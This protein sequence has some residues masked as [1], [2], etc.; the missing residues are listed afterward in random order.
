M[1]TIRH[2]ALP[3]AFFLLASL[4]GL[5]VT[6]A[7]LSVTVQENATQ[8]FT[9]STPS[10]WT[11]SCGTISSTGLY[12]APLYPSSTCKVTATP[13]NGT[14]AAS[15]SINVVS[16]VTMTPVAATTPQGQTQQFTASTSVTWSAKCGTITASGLYT[17]SGTVGSY[18][19]IQGTAI[20]NPKYMV[21]GYDKIAAPVASTFSISPL[22]VTISEGGTQQFTVGSGATFSASCGSISAAGVFTAPLFPTSCT[23][24][25][26]A[27]DGSGQTASTNATVTSPIAISPASATTPLGQTQQF[28]ANMSVAW[29]ASCGTINAA[30]LFTAS[31][32]Q[33]SACTVTATGTGGTAYTASAIETVGAPTALTISPL[34]PSLLE[35]ATQQFTS[36][37]NATWIASCGTIGTTTGTYTAPLAAGTCTITANATDGSGHTASTIA[38]VT[39]PLVITPSTAATPQGSTQQFTANMQSNWTSSCGS[40]NAAGLFTAA[41]AQGSVCTIS[42]TAATAPAYTSSAADTVGAAAPLTISPLNQSLLENATQQFTSSKAATWTSSCGTIGSTT[43]A[44]TAPLAPGIC[45]ITAAATDG[46]GNT[47]STIA[48]ISSPVLITPASATTLQGNTQQFTASAAVTWIAF[49]G[50][51]DA[52]GLFSASSVQGT[53]CSITATAASGPAY[54]ASA[55]DTVGSS[56]AFSIS[57]TQITI[58]ENS[59]QQ[60]TASANA[61]WSADCGTIDPSAGLYTAPLT[62]QICNVTATATDGSGN[63]AS[64]T[65]TVNSPITITPVNPA[66]FAIGKLQ[67]HANMPV[68]WSAT[69]GS[70]NAST[71]LFTAAATA[72]SCV[73]TATASSGPAFTETDNASVSIIN[74]TTFRGNNA[75][76]GA[77][78]QERVLTPDNV[79]STSFGLAWSTKLDGGIWAQPL[80][81]NALTVNGTPHNVVFQATAND[82]VFALDGDTGAILWQRSFLS[83][84]VT[85]VAGSAVK[86]SINPV[87]IVGTP[88][89]DPNSNTL[90]VVA[91]TAENNNTVLIHRLHAI[92]ITTGLEKANSPVTFS[93]PSFIDGN[94]MQRAALLLA[95]NAVYVGFGGINDRPPYQGFI[96]AFDSTALTLNA[97]FND[98]PNSNSTGGGGIWMSGNGPVADGAGTIYV[99]SGNG[100][101]DGLNNF[102]QSVMRLSPTL[103]PLDYFTPYNSVAQSA[104]DFDLGSGGVLMVPDQSGSYE[105]ELIVCGKPNSIYV[106]NRDQMG[107]QGIVTDNIIQRVDGQIGQTG[108]FTASGEA[109]FS[110]PTFWNQN[111][112]LIPNHDVLKM[113]T[114]NASTGLLSATPVSIGSTVY[115]YPGAY[116]S[117]S[118]NGNSDGIVWAYEP[119]SGTLRA[120]DATNMSNELFV[121]AVF[122]ASKWSVPVVVNGHVYIETQNR[123]FAFAP[124]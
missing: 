79:N 21:Y 105:H 6:V 115:T 104:A 95:N 61:T 34:N 11:A 82:S 28:T 74:Y 57:P 86:S 65:I 68:T 123:I 60:F 99:T 48:T 35:N 85:P 26:N 96:F 12:R 112:Y 114:L 3:V 71:G 33:G 122:T 10:T 27:T 72:G 49:C 36:S 100:V 42:A 45:T 69:C 50:S 120:T 25:A 20:S 98:D 13:T 7:P 18:C 67:F 91:M 97:V 24:T 87:G 93:A 63:T 19:T 37:V 73:I 58:T 55:T 109:C 106:L 64:S 66:L 119:T 90:Y 101:S 4:K 44:Y 17:A 53:V 107:N 31:A 102:G 46:S 116:A 2:R 77:Q 110:T 9:A 56:A 89:I 14:G 117:I 92:D 113:F 29:S 15:A 51:I 8:Q 47:A 5:A 84:G 38:A 94:Q 78:T 70:I 39:S 16:P 111:V 62:A 103:Q 83:A 81:M 41:A 76:T 43:G 32:T 118:A 80:Y 40:I 59:P 54:T 88:V 22:N 124:K 108:N 1:G 23:I 52:T 121:G 75:R 30:G